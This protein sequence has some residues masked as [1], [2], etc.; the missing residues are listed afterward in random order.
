MLRM[1]QSSADLDK[2]EKN[3]AWLLRLVKGSLGL[4]QLLRS[5]R[6]CL[7]TYRDMSLRRGSDTK[8]WRHLEQLRTERP[9]SGKW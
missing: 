8:T 4:Q 2:Q 1:W 7:I 9:F 3:R 6:P 5:L